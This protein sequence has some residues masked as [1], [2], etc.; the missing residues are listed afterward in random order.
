[1][2]FNWN[3]FTEEDFVNYCAKYEVIKWKIRKENCLKI[4]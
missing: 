2:K 1:M 4:I 3:G